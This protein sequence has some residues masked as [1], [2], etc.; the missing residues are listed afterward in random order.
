MSRRRRRKFPREPFE[1]VV[2]DLSHD[3]RGVAV[4]GEKR[5]FVHG[6][7]PGERVLARITGRRRRYDEGETVEVLEA[8]PDR[9]E[10]RC[11]HFGEC[12]GCHWQHASYPAQLAYK[13]E[14]EVDPVRMRPHPHEFTL[15]Y[16]V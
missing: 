13:R 11:R 12:G 4:D 15:Y 10:P 9:V 2:E 8:S 7:L 5:V 3:G 14:I 1:I 16:D 6:G